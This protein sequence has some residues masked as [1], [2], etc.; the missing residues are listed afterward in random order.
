MNRQ[1]E[2]W[3]FFYDKRNVFL[4]ND[5][6]SLVILPSLQTLTET[7]KARWI[8]QQHAPPISDGDKKILPQAVKVRML[9]LK[10]Q[11]KKSHS[12]PQFIYFTYLYLNMWTLAFYSEAVLPPHPAFMVAVYPPQG[13]RPVQFCATN[14]RRS[15]LPQPADSLSHQSLLCDAKFVWVVLGY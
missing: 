9:D 3:I 7:C 4:L 12:L 15:C 11:R 8:K 10:K 1:W 6:A 2:F 14:W 13:I 5:E